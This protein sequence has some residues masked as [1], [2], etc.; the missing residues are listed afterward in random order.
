VDWYGT[1]KPSYYYV[2]RAARPVHVAVDFKQYMWKA[3]E[4]FSADI[5]VLND[6]D[7]SVSHC[8]YDAK[9]LD[10]AGHELASQHGIA[11][12][13]ANQSARVGSLTFQIPE[14]MVGEAFFLSA[15][16]KD[17][18]GKLLS[19][20]LYPIGVETQGTGDE[21]DALLKTISRMPQTTL[22]VECLSK[23]FTKLQTGSYLE[24]V[25]IENHGSMIGYNVRLRFAEEFDSVDAMYSDN[26][27]SLLPGESTTIV[28][29]LRPKPETTMPSE[30]HLGVS[31]WNCPMKA[32][33]VSRG[34]P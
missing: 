6:A 31:G 23:S 21:H 13:E 28:V 4:T 5:N 26:Y 10:I 1:P 34:N 32:Y 29:E 3:G 12:A 18:E 7:V 16:I 19:S 27:V 8:V 25:K 2:K 30:L 15:E 17:Q 14:S 22:T 20:V 33:V 9:I 24:R 11:Q